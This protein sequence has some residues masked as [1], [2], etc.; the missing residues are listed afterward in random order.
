MRPVPHPLS[1]ARLVSSRTHRCARFSDIQWKWRS[2]WL[3]RKPMT[4]PL[5]CKP[6]SA[7]LTATC[8]ASVTQ[9]APSVVAA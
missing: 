1:R 9:R 7:R 8:W 2:S 6:S 3:M 5:R 4:R